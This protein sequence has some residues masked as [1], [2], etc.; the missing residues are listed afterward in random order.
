MQ[1]W[2]HCERLIQRLTFGQEKYSISKSRTLGSIK[3]LLLLTEWH[4]RVLHFPPANDGW[5][6]SLAP[7]LDDDLKVNPGVED[8]H[9]ARWREEIFE[10]AKRSDRMSWMLLGLATTLAHEL[11]VFDTSGAEEDT[12]QS[13][14]QCRRKHR[15]RRLLFVYV[16]QLACRIG[17]T[18]MI[19]QD[20]CQDVADTESAS[21]GLADRERHG[22]KLV[23]LW[24]EVTKLLK[25]TTVMFFAS[26]STTRSLLKTGQYA[27]LLEHFH[28]LLLQWYR[29]FQDLQSSRKSTFMFFTS[30]G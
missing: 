25:T 14:N 10:P 15:L 12:S 21:D 26:K 8:N 22:Q 13:Q 18:S 4:P 11:G 27:S 1:L 5:D 16:N 29:S 7:S 24:I 3:A 20:M 17:C 2:S 9:V 6:A 23:G 28:P 19:P 30:D